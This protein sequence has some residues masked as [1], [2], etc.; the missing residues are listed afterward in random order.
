[1][2]D[3]LLPKYFDPRRYAHHELVIEGCLSL[4]QFKEL[5]TV[6]SSDEG[7]AH[8]HLNFRFDEDRRCVANGSLNTIVKVVCQRC[9]KTVSQKL[10]IDLLLAFV[11]DE[12]RAKNI[13]S[14]YD[15]VVMVDGNVIL[16]DMVEQEIILALPIVAYHAESACNPMAIKYAS[17]TDYASD[18][19]KKSNPFSILTDLKAK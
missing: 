13:P 16:V 6:L 8:I 19:E 2:L 3:D 10:S 9:L 15:P 14:C 4:N 17:F 18:G 5:R 1:M 7:D 12:D 11:C